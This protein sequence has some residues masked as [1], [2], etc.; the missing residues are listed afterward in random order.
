MTD[1]IT[2]FKNLENLQLFNRKHGESIWGK[3][4][5]GNFHVLMHNFLS[6]N[7]TTYIGTLNN[8]NH[9]EVL[10]SEIFEKIKKIL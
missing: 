10:E 2:I 8:T 4:Q 9:S 3:D 6:F 1:Y 7:T 5:Q